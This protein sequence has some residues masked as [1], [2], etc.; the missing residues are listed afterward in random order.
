MT[1]IGIGCARCSTDKQDLSA[2][3]KAL[4]KLGVQPDRIYTEHGLTGTKGH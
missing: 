4:V 1:W 3:R 2:Q